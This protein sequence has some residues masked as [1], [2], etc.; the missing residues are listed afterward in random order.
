MRWVFLSKGTIIVKRKL[1]I[2]ESP[3]KFYLTILAHEQIV[4]L[5]ITKRLSP[6]NNRG[7][8]F[9]IIPRTCRRFQ[10]VAST[11]SARTAVEHREC[12]LSFLPHLFDSFLFVLAFPL[13]SRSR[14]SDLSGA[15]NRVS[16]AA[17]RRYGDRW[18][19]L[20]AIA[21]N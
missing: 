21:G 17:L 8:T 1:C 16:I 6:R 18:L 14:P 2:E 5:L 12:F 13:S 19:V 3:L 20:A 15:R 9:V 4:N 11:G 10:Q 7:I